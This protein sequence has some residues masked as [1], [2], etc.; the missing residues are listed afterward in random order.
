M[1]GVGGGLNLRLTWGGGGG[2]GIR[3]GTAGTGGV[4]PSATSSSLIREASTSATVDVRGLSAAER[5]GSQSG[6][7]RRGAGR[8]RCSQGKT[9]STLLESGLGFSDVTAV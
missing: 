1:G 3:S 7:T 4:S 6:N 8:E 5:F 9:A 2:D